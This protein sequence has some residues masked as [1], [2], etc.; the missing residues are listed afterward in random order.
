MRV[1]DVRYVERKVWVYNHAKWAAL[2]TDKLLLN[3][4]ASL[5]LSLSLSLSLSHAHTLTHT[6][7]KAIPISEHAGVP[8]VKDKHTYTH[9]MLS[10][11]P[12]LLQAL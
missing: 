7:S 6:L 8:A 4:Q 11:T 3:N 5:H 1:H 10:V 12:V 9:T 2:T